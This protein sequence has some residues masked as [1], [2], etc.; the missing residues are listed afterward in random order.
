MVS[1]AHE[2]KYKV[3]QFVMF[4]YFRNLFANS[5]NRK[6]FHGDTQSSQLF[7]VG[8]LVADG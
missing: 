1:H 4:M 7:H 3:M 5:Y 8:F 2:I 6:V